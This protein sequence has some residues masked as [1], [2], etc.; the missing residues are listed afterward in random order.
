MKMLTI[1]IP[2]YNRVDQVCELLESLTG[3]DDTLEVLVINDGEIDGFRKV[4]ELYSQSFRIFDNEQNLGYAKNFCKIF[5]NINTPYTMLMADDDIVEI[6]SV[7]AILDK[8]DSYQSDFFSTI[9][10][11]KNGKKA[12]GREVTRIIEAKEFRPAAAHAPGLIYKTSSVIEFLPYLYSRLTK[13]CY[14]TH[15]YPQ[16]VYLICLLLNDK[17]GMW[18]DIVA[19]REGF[20]MKSGIKDP[21]GEGYGSITSRLMQAVSVVQILSDFNKSDCSFDILSTYFDYTA[22]N[23]NKFKDKF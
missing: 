19:A 5:E 3:L 10:L 8:L 9:W 22:Q 17:V 1:A 13:G 23:M 12:R 14:L 4:H 15:T 21:G 11:D 6:D 7:L 18:L 16:V 20:K 2:T